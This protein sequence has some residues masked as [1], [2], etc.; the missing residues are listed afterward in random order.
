MCGSMVKPAS[1]QNFTRFR[2]KRKIF[3][4]ICYTSRP[5]V[6]LDAYTFE[7]IVFGNISKTPKYCLCRKHTDL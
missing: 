4:E 5:S 7:Q 2:I 3:C 1:T 6:N